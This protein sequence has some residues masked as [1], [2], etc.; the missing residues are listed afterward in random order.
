LRQW[1]LDEYQLRKFESIAVI[2]VVNLLIV[3]LTQDLRVGVLDQSMPEA[4]NL[5]AFIADSP[6]AQLM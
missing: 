3:L 6:P 5:S 2:A 4:L 1:A